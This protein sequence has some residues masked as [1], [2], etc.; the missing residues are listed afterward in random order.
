MYGFLTFSLP[1]V[2]S[3]LFEPA[4]KTRARF[5]IHAFPITDTR[6]PFESIRPWVLVRRP[7]K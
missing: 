1:V 7:E 6:M 4:V 5:M 2:N 3:R